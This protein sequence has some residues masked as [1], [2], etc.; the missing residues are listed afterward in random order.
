MYLTPGENN[1]KGRVVM[2]GPLEKLSGARCWVKHCTFNPK[3]K[4]KKSLYYFLHFRG[5]EIEA[6]RDEDM[7]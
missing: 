5:V 4:K 3:K 7:H 2:V 6:P 1:S